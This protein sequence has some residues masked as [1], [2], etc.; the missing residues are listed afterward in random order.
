[1][2]TNQNSQ[3]M[4]N[5]IIITVSLKKSNTNPPKLKLKDSKGN[6][7]GN[8]DLETYVDPGNVI[9]WIPNRSSGISQ[10]TDIQLKNKEYGTNLLAGPVEEI[11]GI[12]Q[13]HVIEAPLDKVRFKMVYKIGFKIY[14]DDTEY[15]CDPVLQ[16]N[17]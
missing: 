3:G 12:L 17:F 4:S 9:T 7:P 1:M 11:D 14:G 13:G 5:S 15:W 10:L 8:E 2:E 16:M 6:K